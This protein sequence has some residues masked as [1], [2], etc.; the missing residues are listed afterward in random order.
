MPSIIIV[1]GPP[2]AGKTTFARQLSERYGLMMLHKDGFKETLFDGLG[3]SDREWSKKIGRA[4]YKLMYHVLEAGLAAGNSFVVESN[5]SKQHDGPVFQKFRDQHKARIIEI[6]CK[7]RPEVAFERF[8]AR[9]ESGK[10]HPG[11][12][13]TDNLEEFRKTLE[14][15]SFEP[16]GGEVVLELDT[17]DFATMDPSAIFQ[18]LDEMLR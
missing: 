12:L 16:I 9:A 1:S 10:R 17:N 2:G 4:S 7:C 6:V 3:W 11:H 15:W 14:G 5:F 13:D 18:R 8:K